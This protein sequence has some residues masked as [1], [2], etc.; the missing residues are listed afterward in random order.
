MNKC[1]NRLSS[2]DEENYERMESIRFKN[3]LWLR[4]GVNYRRVANV[5]IEIE[6]K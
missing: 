3:G 6:A 1:D 2:S 4:M 5:E